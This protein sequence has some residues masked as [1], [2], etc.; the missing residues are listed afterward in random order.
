LHAMDAL[1]FARTDGV[2]VVVRGVRLC[3]CVFGGGAG[4]TAGP[5]ARTNRACWGRWPH[6]VTHGA[7]PPV[8]SARPNSYQEVVEI[9]SDAS[10]Q[11]ALKCMDEHRLSALLVSRDEVTSWAAVAN[12]ALVP[13]IQKRYQGWIDFSCVGWA[14][15]YRLY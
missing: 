2:L 14:C 12:H 10:I 11:A 5:T 9:A 15:A 7:P 4:L 3:L 1:H 8:P 13:I 6:G